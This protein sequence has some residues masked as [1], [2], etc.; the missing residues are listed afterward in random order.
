MVRT[1]G[2]VT[3]A[4]AVAPGRLDPVEALTLLAAELK[5]RA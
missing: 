2:D 5:G 4:G 3:F 1:H